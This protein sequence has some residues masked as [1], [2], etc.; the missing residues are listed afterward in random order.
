MVSASFP[1]WEWATRKKPL[2]PGL[3]RANAASA[4]FSAVACSSSGWPCGTVA[5]EAP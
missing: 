3:V 4:A 2:P 5:A 1:P